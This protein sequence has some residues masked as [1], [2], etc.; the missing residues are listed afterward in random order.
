MVRRSR[1]ANGASSF[2]KSSQNLTQHD[3]VLIVCEDT[4]SSRFYLDDLVKHLQLQSARV[5]VM[6]GSGSAPK[7]VVETAIKMAYPDVADPFDHVFIVIDRDTHRTFDSAMRTFR[8]HNKRVK[9]NFVSIVSFPSFEIWVLYHFIYTRALMPKADDVIREIKKLGFD[10]DKSNE[11]LFVNTVSKIDIAFSNAQQSLK[12]AKNDAEPNPSTD[13]P[14]LIDK[15]KQIASPDAVTTTSITIRAIES[16]ISGAV[17][18]AFENAQ[19]TLLLDKQMFSSL[20]SDL[21]SLDIYQEAVK[22]YEKTSGLG[23]VS[24]GELFRVIW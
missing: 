15:L 3:K 9:E 17:N 19:N 5:H 13:F 7:S 1:R 8:D 22:A 12:E 16:I 6:P 11:D 2:D 14:V 10:Y 23:L 18:T 4:K 20:H 24:Q 21:P